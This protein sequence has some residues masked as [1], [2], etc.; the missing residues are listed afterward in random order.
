MSTVTDHD[1]GYSE[2]EW[3]VRLDLAACYRLAAHFKMTELIH[4]HISARVPG[5]R[6]EF[7]INPYGLWF[8]EVTA[9]S[10]VKIGVDG[11]KIEDS[12]Y[13]VNPAGFIIHA[14]I[15]E[16]REDAH[17]VMHTHSRAGGAVCAL[18][19]GLLPISQH[20]LRFY[21]KIGY[22]AYEGATL[23]PGER[24]R[25]QQSMGTH[26]VLM[27]RN[28]GLLTVGRSVAEAFD[29][30]FMLNLAC[31]IQID[32]LQTGAALAQLPE[33]VCEL[34]ARQYAGEE[35]EDMDARLELIWQA[36]L[37]LVEASIPDY[38]T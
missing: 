25:L 21:G 38:R 29:R 30:M 27:L 8:H 2:E 37:R 20:A 1:Q 23:I 34:P 24:E 17:C 3:K 15:H 19:P 22:H 35:E 31:Q 12:P 36:C 5:T 10:L 18:E 11:E 26:D 6:D 33:A 28:H 7:L 4:T 16:G 14:A 9:S 32:A 13:P